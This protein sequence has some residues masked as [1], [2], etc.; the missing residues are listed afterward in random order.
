MPA[1]VTVLM[2][3]FNGMAYL[4]EAV[5][6]ILGQTLTDFEFLI[7]DDGSSDGSWDRLQAWAGRDA[8][9]RLI[10]NQTNLGLIRALNRGLDAARAPLIARQDADDVSLPHRLAAQVEFLDRHP[11]VAVVGSGVSLIDERGRF[12]GPN[13]KPLDD[14]G[15]RAM[16]LVRTA[17]VHGTVMMRRGVIERLG[18]R[19]DRAMLHAEDYDFFS[20]LLLANQGANLAEPLLRYRI[21]Q[22]S[23]G[24]K[25]TDIQEEVADG[26]AR[27][28][29]ARL[30]I[31]ELFTAEEIALLRHGAGRRQA[32][33]PAQIRRQY[34][35]ACRLLDLLDNQWRLTTHDLDLMRGQL[36]DVTVHNLLRQPGAGA[37]LL[38]WARLLLA[39]PGPLLAY[40]KARR[41]AKTGEIA[42][43]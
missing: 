31:E 40:L 25:Y 8:R 28:N 4:D 36:L 5:A 37:R 24:S 42:T 23:I 2:S 17:F 12:L 11:Q 43:D 10:R 7:V 33:D 21:H 16:M 22:E 30:G 26:I 18:L 19:Y 35:C 32:L 14:Q 38:L 3:V 20:R 1:A 29:F 6:G 34:A 9:V 15:I 27:A 13:P 41:Q 39:Q